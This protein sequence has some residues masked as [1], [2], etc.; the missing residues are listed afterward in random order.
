MLRDENNELKINNTS[1]A[2]NLSYFKN[3]K[4]KQDPEGGVVEEIVSLDERGCTYWPFYGAGNE[5]FYNI[6]KAVLVV[7]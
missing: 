7:S 6:F 4:L 2:N 5:A 1:L 3:V